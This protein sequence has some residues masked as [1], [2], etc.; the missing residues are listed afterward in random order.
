MLRKHILKQ[1]RSQTVPPA[2]S[3]S[4]ISIPDVASVLGI[5]GGSVASD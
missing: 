5:V 4:T 3:A 2:A 1:D